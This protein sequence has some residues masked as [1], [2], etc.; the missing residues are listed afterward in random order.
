MS[1]QRLRVTYDLT[2]SPGE[3]AAE[4]ARRIAFEQTVELPDSCVQP[5]LA[6]RI[7]GRVE[8]VGDLDGLRAR[9]V[10]SYPVEAV[11]NEFPQML[12]LLF[13]NISLQRGIRISKVGWP[14][15]WLASQPGPRFGID[16]LRRLCR[17]AGRRPLLCAALKPMG[18]SAGELA[19]IC[20]E[21]AAG[22]VDLVKDDH[23][24]A[25]Q[26]AAPF[27]ERVLRCQ[28]AVERANRNRGGSTLYA[29]NL[30]GPADRIH[31]R[32]KQLRDTGCRAA[33]ISP[34]L[35][36]PDVVRS[37]ADQSGLALLA[38]P[39]LSGSYFHDDHGIAPEILLG[40]IFRIVG[41]DAVIYPNTGGR[42][43]FTETTCQAI[44]AALTGPL[45]T[46]RPT[47]PTPGGGI[48][49]RRVPHWIDR[50]GNDVIFLVGGSLYAQPDLARAGSELVEAMGKAAG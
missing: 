27:R 38:H 24:L 11:G 28:E 23:G 21:F 3:D 5:D 29:P 8:Q 49:V 42:F 31:E 43:P 10:I 25:D 34:L 36:G 44:N 14:A 13:G 22:G 19:R 2:C 32:V 30:T 18:L 33:L 41:S 6:D 45:G 12:N 16:G 50:Y 47:F 39:A 7:V 17:C 1:G 40:Q 9:A 35:V 20:G 48:D 37:L 15:S 46:L 4:K 26:P